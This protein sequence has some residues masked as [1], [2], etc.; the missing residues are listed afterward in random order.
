MPSIMTYNTNDL[1]VKMT[2]RER[3]QI[4]GQFA[5][6]PLIV[7]IINKLMVKCAGLALQGDCFEKMRLAYDVLWFLGLTPV[8]GSI[9]V[10]SVNG[11][12]SFGFDYDPPESC[13]CWLEGDFKGNRVI[14]DIALPG[15]VIGADNFKDEYGGVD[16]NR[17]PVILAGIVPMWCEYIVVKDL[18]DKKQPE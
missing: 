7:D 10:F 8:V 17:D 3:Y 6:V 2:G 16:L 12:S 14:V 13:H 9:D 18:L 15:V 11:G 4:I 5:G 1:T